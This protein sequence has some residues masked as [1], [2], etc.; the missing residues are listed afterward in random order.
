MVWPQ[1]IVMA[2]LSLKLVIHLVQDGRLDDPDRMAAVIGS[3][4]HFGLWIWLLWMG[5][6]WAPLVAS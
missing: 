4:L 2:L 5:G 1:Y 6:F 3:V